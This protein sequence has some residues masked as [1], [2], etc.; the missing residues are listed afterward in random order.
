MTMNRIT[1]QSLNQLIA[2]ESLA[3]DNAGDD[4]R[5]ADQIYHSNIVSALEE[6]QQRRKADTQQGGAV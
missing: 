3:S 4:K 6:L 2:I 5:Q 1:D